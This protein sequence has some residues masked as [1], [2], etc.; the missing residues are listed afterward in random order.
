VD[1][2]FCGKLSQSKLY[3]DCIGDT[4]LSFFADN[5]VNFYMHF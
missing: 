1:D 5:R 2:N 4:N 3:V